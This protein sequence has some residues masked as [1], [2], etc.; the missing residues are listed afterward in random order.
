MNWPHERGGRVLVAHGDDGC[1]AALAR[2]LESHGYQVAM[3]AESIAAIRATAEGMPDALVLD[4]ALPGAGGLEV[5]RQVRAREATATL[6]V[7]LLTDQTH[8][9]RLAAL[10]AGA[11]YTLEASSQAAEL[12]PW[13]EN[14]LRRARRRPRPLRE[15]QAQMLVHDMR[16]ALMGVIGYL[17]LLRLRVGLGADADAPRYLDRALRATGTLAEMTGAFLDLS[18]VEHGELPLRRQECNLA[19]VVRD[20]VETLAPL[21]APIRLT[22]QIPSTPVPAYCDAV[23]IGRVVCN[24]LANAFRY[25]P[26]AGEVRVRVSG[27]TARARVEVTDTGPGIPAEHHQRVFEKY[28][29]VDAP[30]QQHWHSLGLGLAFCRLAVTAHGGEVGVVSEPGQGSTFWFE[31]PTRDADA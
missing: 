10:A 20:A 28:G 25:T 12:L 15:D 9:A 13:V 3:A 11:D 27:C 1:R 30:G 24:L 29:R 14:A 31:L 8:Q 4:A 6:P 23:V 2:R 16:N 5:C 17:Q 22:L 19:E 7:L 18:R 21:A 26:E